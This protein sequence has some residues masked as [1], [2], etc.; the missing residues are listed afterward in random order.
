[1]SKLGRNVGEMVGCH[2]SRVTAMAY[3][4]FRIGETVNGPT[5][6]TLQNGL[7]SSF[8]NLALVVLLLEV[9]RICSVLAIMA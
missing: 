2:Q 9:H 1:M 8:I 4:R 7:R 3:H 6:T 5:V